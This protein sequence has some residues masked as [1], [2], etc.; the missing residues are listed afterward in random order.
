MEVRQIDVRATL[1]IRQQILRPQLKE[2][3]CL[4]PGDTDPTTTHFGAY[5]GDKQIGIVSLFKRDSG[6]LALT[7]G[8]QI[9]AMA[10]LQE[11]RGK[12]VGL[13]LLKSAENYAFTNGGHHIWANARVEAK[14][15]YQKAGY[16]LIDK[17]E[18]YIE[19]VGWHLLIC[20]YRNT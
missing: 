5:I 11:A 4:F 19:D 8:Y 2:Q 6:D 9:R 13:Q 18:F 3:D 1:G 20:K 7:Q 10:T 12:G 16:Q 17:D 15:F 14:G